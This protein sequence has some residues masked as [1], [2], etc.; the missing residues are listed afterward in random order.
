[1][2]NP[3][4]VHL[5]PE[6]EEAIAA[7]APIVA[8]ESTIITH[9][10]PHPTNA[11]TALEVERI[12]RGAGAVPATIA[13]IDGKLRAGLSQREIA[14]LA[15]AKD[16]D[17][18]SRRDIAAVMVR[19][20]T[21]GTTVAATM[22]I[23]AR[24]GI[25]LF[26][27]GGIGG[28][29]RGAETTFDISAD[30]AELSRTPVAVVSAGVKSILDVAKTAELL[31]SLGVPV[32][33]YQTS[34]FPAFF[35]RA[36]GSPIDHRFDTADEVAQAIAQH[37]AIGAGSGVL[38]ANPIGEADALEAK[39]IEAALEQALGEARERGIAQKETTPFLLSRIGEI[40]AGASVRANVKLIRNNARVAAEVAVAYQKIM[41]S[42]SETPSA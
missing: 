40:T 41:S 32:I 26:A 3:P 18:A 6:V 42:R 38:V 28:V 27:T 37:W 4:V 20:A 17:K 7:R 30:L 31:E 13:I 22:F 15:S 11:D 9:G 14:K 8:F 19:G 16:L 35:S 2:L 36:S 1:M 25:R 21:A 12:A 29:H 5:S 24:A 23:A 39:P 33:G 34:D 10:L